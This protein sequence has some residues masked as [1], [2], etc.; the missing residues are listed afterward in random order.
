MRLI[1]IILCGVTT[2]AQ[3]P[4]YVEY[5]PP[6]TALLPNTICT[7]VICHQSLFRDVQGHA[8]AVQWSTNLSSV[9]IH[10]P[11]INI[12][13]ALNTN[14]S[15]YILRHRT[16]WDHVKFLDPDHDDDDI[17]PLPCDII[18]IDEVPVYLSPLSPYFVILLI[19]VASSFLVP[20]PR[21]KKSAK[22]VG[23][24]RI[25]YFA[26][27]AKFR[28]IHPDDNVA[29]KF[30]ESNILKQMVADKDISSIRVA[31]VAS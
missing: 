3:R 12:E 4:V 15:C 22:P 17:E 26:R 2:V 1:I 11:P 21:S 8:V 19:S 9:T 20:K 31:I 6:K 25:G 16:I 5:H 24:V 30:T 27:S 14:V 10:I 18:D 7:D 23:V 28:H 29:I 13:V